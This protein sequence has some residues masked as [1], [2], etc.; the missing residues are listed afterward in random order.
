MPIDIAQL[1]VKI[2]ADTGEAEKGLQ[3][4]QGAVEGFG[5][6]LKSAASQMLAFTGALIGVK[7]LSDAFGLAK[8]AIIDFNASLEQSR[9]AFTTMLGSAQAAEAFLFDLQK[10]AAQTPFEFQDVER[11]AKRLL[12]M[13]FAARDVKPLLTA[14]GDAAAALG[15]GA[16]G[17]DRIT[18]ALGQMQAKSK[19]ASQEMMQLTEAGI[20]AWEILAQ[21]VGKPIPVVM[22]LVSKGQIASKT[23][24]DAFMEF[25]KLNWGG[26]MEAQSRTFSGALSTIKD[27]LTI[28]AATAFRPL[29]DRIS[30][31]AQRIAVFVQS[32]QFQVWAARVAAIVDFVLKGLGTLAQGFSMAFGA[33]LRIVTSVGQ[34]IWQALQLLNPFARHSPSLVESVQAGVQAIIEKFS[35][36]RAISAPLQAAGAAIDNLRQAAAAKLEAMAQAAEDAKLKVL[37]SLGAAVPQ[38]YQQAKQAMAA[39]ESQ[40]GT[41]KAQIEAQQSV[42]AAAKQKLDEA[43]N[44]VKAKERA[45]KDLE[46]G[47]R[48]YDDAVRQAESRVKTMRDA[49]S[50][51]KDR[52]DRLR[53]ALAAA[54]DRMR[55]FASAPIAG[56]EEFD[57]KLFELD[58]QIN[59]TQLRLTKMRLSG[60]PKE[61]IE[62][63]EQELE[64]LRLEAEQVRLE[65]SLKFDPLRR[66]IEKMVSTSKELT[67]E[68]IVA[69]IQKEKDTIAALQPQLEAATREHE[70]QQAALESA[71]AELAKAREAR[72][73]Y[74]DR[75]EAERAALEF[76]QDVQQQAREAY[77]DEEAKLKNLQDAYQAV[78]Q[79]LRDYQSVLDDIVRQAEQAAR[80]EQE[81]GASMKGSIGAVDELTKAH[82]AAAKAHAERGKSAAEAAA[83]GGNPRLTR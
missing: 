81:L 37:Q 27:S 26:M 53:D 82:E 38:A 45:I 44:A 40:L 11:G 60:A 52:V 56:M 16:P 61:E 39:L 8:G 30:E 77:E 3:R 17:I 75:I 23:F 10:F 4:V 76:L 22:D 63:T 55:Q 64:R 18:L 73:A 12:A 42:T 29:F 28:V 6:F 57:D 24:I 20:P 70:A 48:V 32:D 33:I 62:A 83:A 9:I 14:V 41:L 35:S 1:Q 25:S 15:L 51:A 58:Q 66:Q 69:G 80:M 47:M 50:A 7:A 59:A 43:T 13:G 31:L 46:R 71:E 54:Q 2:G 67:F 65:K 5:G 68:E 21:A 72:D 36:L 49:V 19:V 34:L 78:Q 79:Q 74:K